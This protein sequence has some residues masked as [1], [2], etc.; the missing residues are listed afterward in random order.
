MAAAQYWQTTQNPNNPII[1]GAVR[2]QMSG[3]CSQVVCQT[4][5]VLR[6]LTM[7]LIP[8]RCTAHCS[9]GAFGRRGRATLV[10]HVEHLI[11]QLLQWLPKDRDALVGCAQHGTRV[12]D[13]ALDRQRR[14]PL[15]LRACT[16]LRGRSLSSVHRSARAHQELGWI[17][18]MRVRGTVLP[19]AN[20][21]PT[22]SK[23]HYGQQP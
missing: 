12:L 10:H 17:E 5:P 21:E 8:A 19:P 11:R 7:L 1:S 13:N 22:C 3:H 15:Q 9:A 18:P 20:F 2:G 14:R 16:T 4:L 6:H 23:E